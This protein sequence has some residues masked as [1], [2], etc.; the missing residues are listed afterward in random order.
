MTFG[1]YSPL[2]ISSLTL[3]SSQQ[4]G[5]SGDFRASN[6]RFVLQYVGSGTNAGFGN[7]ALLRVDHSIDTVNWFPLA[8]VTASGT[9]TLGQLFFSGGAYSYLRA[10]LPSVYSGATGTGVVSVAF[11]AN[12][13][14]GG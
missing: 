8:T 5:V 9:G 12:P 2:Y 6:G 4:T 3:A 1:I 11:F 10:V 7:S 13:A 14:G